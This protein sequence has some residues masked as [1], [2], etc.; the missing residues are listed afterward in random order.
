MENGVPTGQVIATIVSPP[1]RDFELED[2]LT[3][4]SLV[5]VQTLTRSLEDVSI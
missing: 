2:V 5:K 3:A 1:L 4:D